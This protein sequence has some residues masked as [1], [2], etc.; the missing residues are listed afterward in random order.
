MNTPL[1]RTLLGRAAAGVAAVFVRSALPG[2]VV[3]LPS[4]C[5]DPGTALA[6]EAAR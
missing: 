3:A 6:A 2:H 1:R 5:P 4:R